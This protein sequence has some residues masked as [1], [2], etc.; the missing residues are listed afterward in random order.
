[1]RTQIIPI[2]LLL[3]LAFGVGQAQVPMFEKLPSSQTNIKFNNKIED[4]KESNILIYSNFYGGAGVGVG[5]F[6]NDGL[7]DLFFAGNLVKDE[8]YINEGDFLFR[9]ITKKAGIKDNGGWSSGVVV[10]DVNNDG[11]QDIYV[12][13]ELYDDSPE[14]R[15]NKLYINNGDLT[16]TEK[17]A[18]YLADHNGRTRHA[19][20]FDYNKDGWL[21]L[22]L[23]T[24]PPNPGSYSTM[25]G[26][27][28]GLYEYAPVLL[29]NIAGK[30]FEDVSNNSGLDV[31]GFPNSASATDFNN[32]G[33]VDLYI[34]NDFQ[35]PDKLYIN[36]RDGTFKNTIDS[37]MG[38]IT[39]F[40][41]GV[42]AADINNDG[43]MDI[44]VLD[45]AA[46]DNYRVKANMSGMNPETFWNIYKDGGHYQYMYNSLQL[47]NGATS[48]TKDENP[49]LSFSDI[50]Q[51]SGTSS[52]DWSWSNLIADLDND[53]KKDIY[54]TNG[55]LRDIR[56]T[57]GDK[58]VSN[59]IS[60]V[61][62]QFIV[63]NPDAEDVEIWDILDL[64]KALQI[65]PSSP[66]VNYAY[67]NVSGL[68]FMNK[69][70]D[71]GLDIPSFSNGSALADLDNDGALDLIVSN[72]NDE[73]FI[74]RNQTR[75]V[76][77]NNYLKVLLEDK[78]PILG[79]KVQI[80]SQGEP[81]WYEF[82]SIRGMYSCSEQIAHFGLGSS[83]HVDQLSVYWNDGNVTTLKNLKAN[84]Q[85][86]IKKSTQR[87]KNT[88]KKTAAT[89]YFTKVYGST[90]GLDFEH[91]ENDFDDY[92]KQILLP[93]KMSQIGPAMAIGD[94]N[95]DG[96]D[97]MYLGGAVGQPGVLYVQQSDG[98]FEKKQPELWAADA[99]YEDVAAVLDDIDQ[100]GD[101]DLYVVSGG[102]SFEPQSVN[103]Q[104]R[105]YLNTDGTFEKSKG[106]LPLF[107]ESGACVR[108]ADFDGDG[109][110]DVFVG[111]R[112][113][114]WHYPEPATSRLLKNENG[115]FVDIT[116]EKAC[117]LENL[118]MVTDALWTDYDHDGLLDLLIVGEWMPITVMRN[119]G[120]GFY[121]ATDEFDLTDTYGWWYS[122]A[123]G[124]L[125]QDGIS[126]Y[127]FGNLG[128][129]YKYKATKEEP[130]EV[131]YHD[132]DGNG[133]KDIVLSYYN[134]GEKYPLRG[135]SC[136]AQQIP[137]IKKTFESY[138][139]FAS[140]NL[141][142]V[143]G[144]DQLATALSH[145]AQTFAHVSFQS[146][147]GSKYEI[148]SLPEYTQISSL[149]DMIIR[150][151]NGDGR[152]DLLAI[153]NNFPVE[154]E[155]PR[156]DAGKGVVL[157]NTK[158]GLEVKPMSQSGFFAPNDAKKIELITIKGSL[159]VVVANNDDKLGLFL[160]TD[161]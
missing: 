31:P 45:M 68:I 143:Y 36:Q 21:D 120:N 137:Q 17:S 66:L 76:T 64:D 77:N 152:S 57:D 87:F 90:L 108:L 43:Y 56:N 53:G 97:D 88:Q 6:N 85:L 80:V 39:Y 150:D 145:K 128:L 41:M 110:Q 115:R 142:E 100:D 2:Y 81:Q 24:Q 34:S 126:D 156:N 32:D 104:D 101:L 29:K 79:A 127:V 42:D 134:F 59:Y 82:T 99:G 18:T 151:I 125:N 71:W 27:D 136:S 26:S 3:T 19:L 114:P 84:Q 121:N 44:N 23:L 96:L 60:K 46:E 161:Q 12:T 144:D 93:H 83:D 28:L 153:G 159:Y 129:N 98:I 16:F 7:Q 4:T 155:T 9:N 70:T 73:A 124:E 106:V 132:F 95:G 109:D 63:A 62:Y 103:Y 47:N 112:H 140:A 141:Y 123:Q 116:T 48:A 61:I 158:T 102:N 5:D 33:W 131:Y 157:L 55:L 148:K 138:D 25:R 67:Q 49:S 154:I 11:W 139:L 69:T 65:L 13:R 51:M 118:G 75:K 130:F 119:T 22:F 117:E 89:S 72:I 146:L 20:F 105:V 149:N 30:Y 78:E 14:L 50:G 10:G 107:Y 91:H 58:K 1:M 74:F 92:A 160:V 54:I 113:V 122:V 8:L 94:I 52:T 37:S 15:K 111:G 147:G 86:K 35:A 40:S 135:R 133:K 38:H